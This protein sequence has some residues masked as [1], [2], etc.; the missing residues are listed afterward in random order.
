MDQPDSW[1][2]TASRLL[3]SG[4]MLT[5]IWRA[6]GLPQVLRGLEKHF[7]GVVLRPIY[8][9]ATKPAIRVVLRAVRDSHAALRIAPALLLQDES[10]NPSAEAA[11]IL[12]DAAPLQLFD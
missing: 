2:Q 5:L 3:R 9:T 6:E 4:G 7:G 10:G 1:T 12:R 8:S 11:A